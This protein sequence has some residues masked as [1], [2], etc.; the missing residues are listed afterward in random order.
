MTTYRA[1]R[2]MRAMG[3]VGWPGAGL[4]VIAALT[5]VL[6][7][8]PLAGAVGPWPALIPLALW[9]SLSLFMSLRMRVTVTDHYLLIWNPLRHY[10]VPLSGVVLSVGPTS[11]SFP[12]RL[13][14]VADHGGRPVTLVATAFLSLPQRTDLWQQLEAHAADTA[15]AGLLRDWLTAN[16]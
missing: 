15:A 13:A 1:G 4:G 12:T 3:A 8:A 6:I 16:P 7:F 14:L 10:R 11:F 2:L 9:F 5:L